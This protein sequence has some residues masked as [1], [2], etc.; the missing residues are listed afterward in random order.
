[1]KVGLN[2][3]DGARYYCLRWAY[4]KEWIVHRIFSPAERPSSAAAA[5][6]AT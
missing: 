5:T 6:A 2:T 1:V 3:Q 4:R